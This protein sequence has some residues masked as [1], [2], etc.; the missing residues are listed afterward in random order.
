MNSKRA[1]TVALSTQGFNEGRNMQDRL[2]QLSPVTV[3]QKHT[4]KQ[5]H[6]DT[7]TIPQLHSMH[8]S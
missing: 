1:Q 2:T 3:G 8:H 4:R 6:K 5:L 7:N